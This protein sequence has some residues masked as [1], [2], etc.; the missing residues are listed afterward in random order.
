[1]NE[2]KQK[3]KLRRSKIVL[4]RSQSLISLVITVYSQFP[5]IKSKECI[6]VNATRPDRIRFWTSSG[7]TERRVFFLDSIW[8]T[9][10]LNEKVDDCMRLVLLP[11]DY[12]NSP[13]WISSSVMA[14]KGNFS[15]TW[16]T[17][18]F[19]QYWHLVASPSC[20]TWWIFSPLASLAEQLNISYFIKIKNYIH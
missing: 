10:D 18:S 3:N 8:H 15:E 14:M 17:S 13:G 11:K 1:M 9:V 4:H 20:T 19:T 2:N 7:P 6:T 12:W 16:L 5:L